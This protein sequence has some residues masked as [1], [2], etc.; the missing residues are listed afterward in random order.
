M[1]KIFIALSVLAMVGFMAGPALAVL[2][3]NDAVPG[4][5]VLA[6]FFFVEK[7]SGLENTYI[8]ITEVGGTATTLN[9][10][11]YT[12]ASVSN[13]DWVETLTARECNPINVKTIID[14]LGTLIKATYE[15]TVNDLT[16]YAGYIELNQAT[17]PAGYDNLIA[18]AYQI[19]L[20]NGRASATPI[21]TL[22]FANWAPT[23]PVI[24]NAVLRTATNKEALTPNALA[25]AMDRM[26]GNT[27]TATAGAF[28]LVTRFYMS[29]TGAKN[30]L[31]IYSTT[32][33]TTGASTHVKY[34]TEAET[35]YS[36]T[37]PLTQ[38][39]NIIDLSNYLDTAVT[40]G[41][42]EWR[43]PQ[44][45]YTANDI[46]NVDDEVLI[47]YSYMQ[48]DTTTNGSWNMMVEMHRDASTTSTL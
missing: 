37:I 12:T 42:I 21:P 30:Y 40:A 5:D 44:T 23:G 29:E 38:E 3:T 25:Y 7:A 13:K 43:Y 32:N 10:N 16:Y 20:A 31:F 45:G 4:T 48:V 35:A 1:K 34:W 11:M 46:T 15:I 19:D 26:A 39:L 28:R 9:G 47:G 36:T 6:P 18:W 24:T 2:G 41:S 22:E 27:G 17:V 33:Q 14:G 8:V